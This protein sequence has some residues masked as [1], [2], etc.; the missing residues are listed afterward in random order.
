M[1]VLLMSVKVGLAAML[2]VAG[3]AK[4]ADLGSFAATVRL[5]LPPRPLKARGRT[6]ALAVALTELL[7]GTASLSTPHTVWLNAAVAVLACAFVAVSGLGY[8]FYRGRTC[9]CFGALSQRKFD[10][11]GIVRSVIVVAGAFLVT[12]ADRTWPR[13]SVS[14]D[15]LL[16]AAAVITAI[17]SFTAAWTLRD[18]RF[19]GPARVTPPVIT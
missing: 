18:A 19:G 13:I 5:F 9:A 14:L 7:I 1:G 4:L 16:V 6:I 3:G 11:P 15:V 10:V 8:L 2:L 12:F 17:A